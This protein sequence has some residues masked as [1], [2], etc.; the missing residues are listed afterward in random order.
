VT[1]RVQAIDNAG[2]EGEW[3]NPIH[4]TYDATPPTGQITYSTTLPTQGSVTATLVPSESVTVTDDG[5]VFTHSFTD[6]GS[7]TFHFVDAA[8]NTGE[9]TATV[10]NIDKDAPIAPTLITPVDNAFINSTSLTNSWST[11]DDAVKYIYESYTNASATSLRWHQEIAA[12]A[13]SKT[14]T[15]VADTTFWWRV[16]AVDAAGNESVW[17]T[18]WKVTVDNTAPTSSITSPSNSQYFNGAINIAGNTQDASGVNHVDLSYANF[19]GQVC[20]EYSP[21]QTLS[22]D[23]STT[24][25]SWNYSWTPS[26]QGNYCIKAAGTDVAGNEEHSAVVMGITYDTTNPTVNFIPPTPNN[27]LL[28]RNNTQTFSVNSSEKLSQAVLHFGNGTGGFESGTDGWTTYGKVQVVTE[29]SHTGTHSL[30]VGDSYDHPGST[31]YAYRTITLPSSGSI[32]LN[33]WLYRIAN[34]GI[35]WDQQRIYVTDNSGNYIR[36]LMYTLTNDYGWANVNYDLSDLHGQTVRIY[37]YTHDDGAGDPSWMYV[38]DVNITGSSLSSEYPM[39]ISTDGLSASYTYSGIADGTASY[40]VTGTDLASNNTNTETRS[41]TVDTQAP[42]LSEKTPFEGWYNTD[43]KSVFT[44]SD[45]NGLASESEIAC[46]ISSEGPEQTCSVTP[47]ICDNAGNCTGEESFI[48]DGANIDKTNPLVSLTFNPV[49]PELDNGWYQTQPEIT[50]NVVDAN[51]EMTQYQWDGTLDDAWLNYSAPIKPATEGEH[52]LYFRAFDKA[53]NGSGTSS[54]LV[55]W[56]QTEIDFAPKNIQANPN[57]TSGTTSKIT[58]EAAGDNV[59]INRYEIKWTLNDTTTPTSYSKSVASE[60][61]ETEIDQLTE[62][63][64]TV[65]VR[66]FDSAGHNKDAAID[67]FVDRTAPVSPTLVLGATGEGTVDLSWNAID[68]AK[69][70][71]IW[72]GTTPGGR[73]YGARV[74]LTTSY[75][76]RGL[77]AGNYYFIVRSVDGAQNQSAESNEVNTGTI[78]GAPGVVEG[79]PAEGFTPEVQGINTDVTPT[80]V[81]DVLG[82]TTDG[83][84][85]WWWLLLLLVPLYFGVRRTSKKNK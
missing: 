2:N 6:N 82:I 54:S 14:A 21:I 34:D 32:N 80:P 59:G 47:N 42:T 27:N 33:A 8:G 17:S 61:R 3:S 35:Y 43:Q 49:T 62:G 67:L 44:F 9:V 48:S 45:E 1:I 58:W 31:N 4:Y 28:T 22:P 83:K 79:T 36:E 85:N 13:T 40:F 75:T 56:D 23:G 24:N 81:S 68:D 74:G 25:Y 78:V 70:Y 69:D 46:T 76:V 11:V 20:G 15:G 60:V 51:P 53:N 65:S 84:L 63:R 7:F 12:P 18:L 77:G 5:G 55:K 29:Q 16:K 39:T 26:A 64:W 52:T 66:A 37:F 72:Y 19:N 30:R 10:T 41:I 71:I 57:P 38:D 73:L 50:I